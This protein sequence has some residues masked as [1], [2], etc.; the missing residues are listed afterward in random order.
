M[1]DADGNEY[2]SKL[3]EGRDTDV[4]MKELEDDHENLNDENIYEDE[5]E[6]ELQE[7]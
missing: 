6:S 4:D 1:E 2:D 7:T 5:D 3:S